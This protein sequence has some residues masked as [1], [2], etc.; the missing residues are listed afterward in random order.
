MKLLMAVSADG[1]LCTGQ[2]DPM[3]WTDPVDKKIFRALTGVGGI[4]AVG[5]NTYKVM[6]KLDGRHLIPISRSGYSLGRFRREHPNGWLLGGP[7]LARAAFAVSLIREF[8]LCWNKR[9]YLGGGVDITGQLVDLSEHPPAMATD[10]GDV[11]LEVYRFG[12]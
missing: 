9:V 11:I 2:T 1:Y 7:T 3:D 6:P 10:F 12:T 4:C 8:H 5:S